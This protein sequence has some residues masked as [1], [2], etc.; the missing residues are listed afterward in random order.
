MEAGPDIDADSGAP[1]HCPA[2][3]PDRLVLVSN[4]VGLGIVAGQ[5]R[6][7]PPVS[8]TTRGRHATNAVGGGRR[9]RSSIDLR[10]A[11][12]CPLKT[13]GPDRSFCHDRR[14]PD[15]PKA[16]LEPGQDPGDR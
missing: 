11:C 2:A 7:P 4:E 13:H 10:G 12:R 9:L 14:H 5:T 8:G 16:E 6:S 15:R 1:R 3:A